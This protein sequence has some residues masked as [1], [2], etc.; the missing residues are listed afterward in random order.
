MKVQ[1]RGREKHNFPEQSL[2]QEPVGMTGNNQ[3]VDTDLTV[4]LFGEFPL[5]SQEPLN[6]LK[7]QVAYKSRR[8]PVCPFSNSAALAQRRGLRGGFASS[9]WTSA[10]AESRSSAG[11]G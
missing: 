6:Q 7:G 1:N 10:L 9:V 2:A 8:R 4:P 11:E 5:C 3:P